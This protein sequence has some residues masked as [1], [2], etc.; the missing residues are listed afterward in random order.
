MG[1]QIN[2]VRMELQYKNRRGV[3][4]HTSAR[5]TTEFVRMNHSNRKHDGLKFQS[6]SFWIKS[7]PNMLKVVSQVMKATLA[8]LREVKYDEHLV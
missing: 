7:L 5:T 1:W 3:N 8:N 6:S 2:Q 4:I